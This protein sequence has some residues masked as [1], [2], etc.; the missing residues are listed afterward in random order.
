MNVR[1]LCRNLAFATVLLVAPVLRAQDGVQGA[2]ASIRA[3]TPLA[4]S[5]T[6]LQGPTLAIADFDGDNKPDGAILLEADRLRGQGNFKIELHLTEHDNADIKFQS[7]EPELT[8]EALDIDHDGDIDL[9][10][11]QSV[12]RK[13]LQVWINDGHGNFE[14]VRIEDFPSPVPTRQQLSSWQRLDYPVISLPSQRG[15]E[16]MLMASHIA[17]RPP[18]DNQVAPSSKNL[19]GNDRGFSLTPSRGPPLS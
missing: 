11:E 10:I 2:L 14:K 16:T 8:V 9:V 5:F 13:R 1:F 7:A 3:T 12:T 18:S 17:G 6:S 4:Q 19:F 15:F